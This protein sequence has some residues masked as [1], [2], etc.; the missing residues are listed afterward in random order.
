MI[1]SLW[2]GYWSA[3]SAALEKD[4]VSSPSTFS[5]TLADS[6]EEA[7]AALAAAA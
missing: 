5:V 1:C 7:I 6:P 3:R 2:R 4:L